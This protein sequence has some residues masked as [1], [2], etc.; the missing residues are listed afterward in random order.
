MSFQG[1]V[2]VKSKKIDLLI[3]LISS[4][5]IF[6][7]SRKF[8]LK[9]EQPSARCCDVEICA[10]RRKS[11]QNG[12]KSSVKKVLGENKLVLCSVTVLSHGCQLLKKFFYTTALSY[13]Y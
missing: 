9:Y 7:K 10:T 6:V 13:Y 4:F 12:V 2:Y 3:R 8:F 11:I 5:C 1:L